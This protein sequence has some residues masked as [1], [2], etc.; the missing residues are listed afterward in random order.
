MRGTIVQRGK[1]YAV[2]LDIGADP[3]TGKRRQRWHAAPDW[4][5]AQ[6]L[7][8]KLLHEKDIGTYSDPSKTPLKDHLET[9]LKLVVKPNLAARTYE[10]YY[11][12]INTYI[13]PAIG[14]IKLS[15][16]T[17]AMLQNLYAGKQAEGKN[18]SA[19]LVHF[20]IKKSLSYAVKTGILK[21]N[22]ADAVQRPKV[23]KKELQVM[24]EFEVRAFLDE[25]KQT[26]YYEIFFLALFTGLRRG[27]L[28]ALKWIDYEPL[29]MQ[30]KV[31]RSLIQVRTGEQKGQLIVKTPKTDSGTRNIELS[32]S[33][34]HILNEYRDKQNEARGKLDLPALKQNDL[35]FCHFNGSPYLPD[36]LSHAFLDIAHRAGVNAHLHSTRHTHATLLIKQQVDI[37]TIQERLGHHDISTT[38]STYIHGSRQ[39]QRAAVD[40]FDKVFQITRESV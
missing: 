21:F 40:N 16:I 28:C 9:W 29:T 5:S 6:K 35:I 38:L 10:Q 37:K 27:E 34:C 7:L 30:L 11:S 25:A 4:N 22:P 33:T 32:P 2:V 1:H 39:L 36:N 3:L 26:E 15:K 23:Q 19:E 31:A 18:R 17:P 20:I 8:S 12:V 13:A 14:N 24:N